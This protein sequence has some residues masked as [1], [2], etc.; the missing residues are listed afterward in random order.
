MKQVER[1]LVGGC[2]TVQ[3]GERG[4]TILSDV[5][6]MP[7]EAGGAVQE[8][9]VCTPEIQVASFFRELPRPTTWHGLPNRQGDFLQVTRVVSQWYG[10]DGAPYRKGFR[11]NLRHRREALVRQIPQAG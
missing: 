2:P 11:V 7:Q 3:E 8:H 6:G 10:T 4:L 1:L 9:E 5:F